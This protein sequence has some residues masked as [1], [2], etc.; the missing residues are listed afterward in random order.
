LL[1]P[2]LQFRIIPIAE[3]GTSTNVLDPFLTDMEA[4]ALLAPVDSQNIAFA[5]MTGCLVPEFQGN[6][7]PVRRTPVAVENLAAI[8][9][10]TRK[11]QMPSRHPDQPS[12]TSALD[13]GAVRSRG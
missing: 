12:R 7:V 6:A 3:N 1:R 2:V 10:G 11:N 4:A 5:D 8:G 13:P 9:I